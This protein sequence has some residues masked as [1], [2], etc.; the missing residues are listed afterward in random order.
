MRRPVLLLVLAALAAGALA[1]LTRPPLEPPPVEE[2][3]TV[4]A[5]PAAP[6][7]APAPA[8]GRGSLDRPGDA[9]RA[10]QLTVRV[11]DAR[12]GSPVPDCPLHLVD[13]GRADRAAVEAAVQGPGYFAPAFTSLGR[14][15][16]TDAAGELR[17]Q[18]SG[19]AVV[20]VAAEDPVGLGRWRPGSGAE[21]VVAVWPRVDFAA[22]VVDAAGEPV[23]GVGVMLSATEGARRG[24]ARAVSGADGVA[25]FPDFAVFLAEAAAGRRAWLAADLPE[26][27]PR[28][29]PVL[30]DPLPALPVELRLPPAG[31]VRVRVSGLDDPRGSVGLVARPADPALPWSPFARDAHPL[32]EGSARFAPVPL[33]QRLVATVDLAGVDG[34]PQVEGRG[35][36]RAGEEVELVLDL[37]ALP[38]L[39]GRLVGESRELPAGRWEYRLHGA[40]GASA[41]D[42]VAVSPEGDFLLLVPEAQRDWSL[43]RLELAPVSRGPLDAATPALEAAVEL[44]GLPLEG[45][46]DLGEVAVRERPLLAAGRVVDPGGQPLPGAMVT[47]ERLVERDLELGER[48]SSWFGARVTSGAGGTFRIHGDAPPGRLRLRA[49]ARGRYLE[50]PLPLAA[51]TEGLELVLGA[52]GGV[53]LPLQVPPGLD[54]RDLAL[55]ARPRA[56]PADPRA[57][58]LTGDRDGDRAE[59]N[60]LPPGSY[61]LEVGLRGFEEPVLRRGPVPVAAGATA[62]LSGADLRGALAWVSLTIVDG[63]GRGAARRATVRRLTRDGRG[64]VGGFRAL[65]EFRV[66]V[67]VVLA[68][69]RDVTVRLEGHRPA[70]LPA[71]TRD[72]EVVLEPVRP[73]TLV[74]PEDFPSAPP[75][76]RLRLT[77]RPEWEPGEV[78]A[79]APEPPTLTGELRPGGRLGADLPS[80]GRYV[81][82]WTFVRSSEAGEQPVRVLASRFAVA[83]AALGGEMLV[84]APEEE[85]R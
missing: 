30:L 27:Q 61:Q 82:F 35:P 28:W 5:A 75:G 20:V 72:A 48:W 29:V 4:P 78:D 56:G 42:T 25:R 62:E 36:A 17:W 32:A 53:V 33:G 81:M 24:N 79:A 13:F 7:A 6:G 73:T 21:L 49:T 57:G 3:A 55:V 46:L 63:E 10:G 64:G 68:D 83:E 65:D 12:D 26:P 23:A 41:G 77:L 1:V 38:L 51:G 76:T 2:G 40:D 52:A 70:R 74:L 58:R 84:P 16:R 47:V 31:A 85:P 60:A 59:W 22:R 37:G 50:R 67:P 19:E 14:A 45:S 54:S 80:A 71:L 44:P 39:R 11:V 43:S 69:P 66:A 18:A 34:A 9:P 8:E 15:V